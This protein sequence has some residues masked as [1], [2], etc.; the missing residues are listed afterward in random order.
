MT[1]PSTAPSLALSVGPQPLGILPPP[2]GFLLL[3]ESASPLAASALARLLSGDLSGPL[4]VEWE[5]YRQA[6]SGD[7]AAALAVL[8]LPNHPVAAY[9]RFVLSGDLAAF[10]RLPSL[11]SGDLGRLIACAAFAAGE[12]DCLPD[13]E[14]AEMPTVAAVAWMVR[15]AA[16]M[17]A[18]RSDQALASLDRGIAAVSAASPTFAAQLLAQKAALLADGADPDRQAALAAL[19]LG[20]ALVPAAPG[21]GRS[22]VRSALYLALGQLLQDTA[23][24][25]RSGLLEA[26]SAYQAAIHSGLSLEQGAESYALAQNNLGLAYLSLP[27][28][29]GGSQ[30]RLGIAVQSFRE[31]LKVWTP[32]LFPEAWSSAQLNLA[33]AL[34]YLPSSHPQENLVQAVEIYEQLLAH[35]NRAFDPL[36][37]ARLLANQANAL[38]HLGIFGPAL[39][40]LEEAHKLFRWHG[41]PDLAASTLEQVERINERLASPAVFMAAAGVTVGVEG[42]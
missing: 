17:E 15:A 8:E 19:R 26:V 21:G 31:A 9:D 12:S 32:E 30:L 39:T 38:A 14:A 16:E 25:D 1:Q 23:A 35:R 7:L 4:P 3:P 27:M 6:A 24:G 10:A 2:A 5:F 33:N 20:I 41:E 18:G 37:Y 22:P 34:Q 29:G 11:F 36:G 28:S 40:K 42:G 13:A